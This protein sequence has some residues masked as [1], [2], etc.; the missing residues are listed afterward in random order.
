MATVTTAGPTTLA[1]RL[2]DSRVPWEVLDERYRALLRLV[3]T[4]L[5]VVPNC[6]RYL[7]IWPPAFRTY[8]IM[9]PNLLNLP[10]PILGV[11]GPPPGVVGLAMY[12]ASRTAECPYCSAHSCSFAMRRGASPATVAAALLPDRSGLGRGELAAIAVARSLARVPCEL[13]EAEKTELVEVYGER[14]AEWIV[15]GVVMMGFLNKF[16]DALGVELEQGV[17]DETSGTLGPGW[18]PGKNGADLDPLA[19]PRPL[20]RVDGWRTR[21]ALLPLLGP[22]VRYDA[23]AQRGT[24]RRA[25]AIGAFL[26]RQLGHDLPVLATLRSNRARRAVASMVVQNLDARSSVIGIDAKLRAG[27]IYADAVSD[28]ALAGDIRALA[29]HAG[30]DVDDL[31]G[32]DP[33][34]VLARAASPSPARVDASTLEAMDSAGVAAAG[35]VELITF[36]GVLQLLHRLSCWARPTV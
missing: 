24:P 31:S 20:P 15:L 11:G 12:V 29:R 6:D 34:L 33:W 23:R 16:M 1:A 10:V 2:R 21:V 30:V 27:A 22:A 32:D 17:V 19:P 5:G 4:L 26:A 18:S 36:L 13:T 28:A 9:V 14:R 8:N 35:I 3:D 7:E 25:P